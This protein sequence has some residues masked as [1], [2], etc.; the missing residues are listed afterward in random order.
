MVLLHAARSR[1]LR[2]RCAVA[3]FDHG[4]GPHATRAAKLVR[5]AARSFGMPAI[6]GR[7]R[8]AGASEAEWRELR[9]RFLRSVARRRGATI[10]TA[11]TRDDQV[12]TIVMRILRGASARGLAALYA[13]SDI[14][15]PLLGFRRVDIERY[16]RAHNIVHVDD[17]TN[18]L[19]TF[20][21]S[22]VRHDILP[23]ITRARPG[24][25][26]DMLT[27]AR[28]AARVRHSTE[29]LAQHFVV[30]SDYGRLEID[31][32]ALARLGADS[33]ALLWPALVARIGVPLDRRAIVRATSFSLTARPGQQAQC[34]GGVRLERTSKKIVVSRGEPVAAATVELGSAVEFGEWRLCRVSKS[35]FITHAAERGS[36]WAAAL[37][38]PPKLQVRS[39][40]PGD[41]IRAPGRA[42]PRRLKRFFT[43]LAIP[44]S[45]RKTW[46]VVVG[47]GEIVWVPGVC[48]T[49]VVAERPG[50]Q[51]TYMICERRAG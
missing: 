45:E 49:A 28:R 19:R 35:T 18:A 30:N 26:R 27:I 6:A 3:T 2:A 22:R 8:A 1:T 46:P 21:R 20:F 10:V 23:A 25:E 15:R 11:H 47:N 7:A 14:V 44:V 37:E 12:E 32:A 38:D 34:S 33:L 50:H 9:F 31:A 41:R 29:R 5:A 16:A 43:E 48:G 36:A 13:D 40:R 4:T 24:F 42:S 39:W 51:L 17:P